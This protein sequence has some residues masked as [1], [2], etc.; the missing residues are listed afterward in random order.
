MDTRRTILWMIFSFSLLLLWNNWQVHNGRPSLFGLGENTVQTDK[1]AAQGATKDAGVPT[2]VATPTAPGQAATSTAAGTGVPAQDVEHVGQQVHVKTDV[3][4]LTFDTLGAQLVQAELLKYKALDGSGDPMMLLD[5]APGRIYLAQTGVVGAPQG[6]SYPTHLTPFTLVSQDTS[7]DTTTV[8]FEATSD[9][10]KVVKTFTLH[11]DS[12]DIHVRHDIYNLGDAAID[13]SVYLQLTRDGNDPPN[14]SGFYSTF[15][16]PVVYSSEEKFQKIDF[17][18]L[19]E[20]K[21]KYVQQADDGWIGMVQHY[22]ASA[23]VPAEGASRTN[24]ALRVAD[25]LYAV[26]TIEPV[27]TI[28]PGEHQS[29]DSQLWTGPQDQQAMSEV[30]PGLDVVVDYGWVTIIAKP[31][32]K[33]MTWLHSLLG[34]WGWTIVALTL[35]I[36]LV[37]YPLSAASY[38]SMAKMKLVAPR[39]KT[40]RDKY[41]DDKAKLNAAMMEMYRTEKINPLGG[42][43]PM[44]VQIP[45]FI[46]LYWVLLA[47]VEMRGAPWILWI[48]DLSVRDPWFILPAVMMAT[49]F[50]QIKLNPTP[51]DP[52]QAKIMM[53]MPLVFGGMMFFFPA[54]LVLYWCVNNAISLVQQRVIM[55]KL[56]KEKAASAS[57]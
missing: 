26:R 17:D 7:G 43:L 18:D 14:T 27:G 56:D 39:M 16:G 20:G 34:N 52:T 38:R 8:V 48:H 15:T 9:Q 42:C 57:S 32:F 28:A 25:N 44:V 47:S 33:F 30:A 4:D 46:A 53:I 51:P 37:F 22:F 29:I 1:P 6:Q 45:V 19:I 3:F 11:K 31:M 54:G 36:K 23:W 55:S 40:L 21:A 12:Y 35:L 50:L 41:G 24:Q 13:P 49:M 10:V 5:D 2:H